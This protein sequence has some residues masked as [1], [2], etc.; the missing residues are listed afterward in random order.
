MGSGVSRAKP[1]GF[2]A[3][4]RIVYVHAAMSL[5]VLIS[6]LLHALQR[7]GQAAAVSAGVGLVIAVSGCAAMVGVARNRS[8]RALV[9]LRCLLWVTVAKV[10]L[11][12]ITVLRTSDSATAE[13]LRAILL[14]EA[15]L[16]PLAI[17]W[18]RRIHTTYLAAV[19][20]T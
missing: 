1:F 10:G 3:L 15:V 12:L 14:N 19:A 2:D 8:L 5:V 4:A 17:Y 11:G 7:G 16:I 9:M 18:S 13:S 6:V 20:K